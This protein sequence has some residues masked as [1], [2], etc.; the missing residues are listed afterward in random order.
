MRKTDKEPNYNE[1][2]PNPEWIYGNMRIKRIVVCHQ[3]TDD[4]KWGI[5]MSISDWLIYDGIESVKSAE[6]LEEKIMESVQEVMEDYWLQQEIQWSW[7]Y[8]HGYER[9]PSHHRY[10]YTSSYT[11]IQDPDISRSYTIDARFFPFLIPLQDGIERPKWH[12]GSIKISWT[13]EN[14]E[15]HRWQVIKYSLGKK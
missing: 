8:Y 12:K 14:K 6:I 3:R 15:Y 9:T 13:E 1:L 11:L 4:T 2:I 7:I 5:G 10:E